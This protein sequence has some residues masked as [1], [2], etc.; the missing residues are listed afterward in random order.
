MTTLT[1]AALSYALLMASA[2]LQVWAVV[3]AHVGQYSTAFIC[4][5]V[6]GKA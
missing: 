6:L 1:E 4:E 3:M 5:K 2:P